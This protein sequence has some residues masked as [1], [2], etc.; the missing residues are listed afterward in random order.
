MITVAA[1]VAE[2]YGWTWPE[3]KDGCPLAALF[4]MIRQPGP[5]RDADT[6]NI[7]TAERDLY[8][9]MD[10]HGKQPGDDVSE[11]YEED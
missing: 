7:S 5:F 11:Y 4:L 8:D 3:I 10:A 9:W 2:R 1:I 6:R